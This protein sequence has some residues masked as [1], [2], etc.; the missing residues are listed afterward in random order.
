MVTAPIR[1]EFQNADTGRARPEGLSPRCFARVRS[2]HYTAGTEGAVQDVVFPGRRSLGPQAS[3]Q[4]TLV[5]NRERLGGS[6]VQMTRRR[7]LANCTGRRVACVASDLQPTTAAST[8][9][10]DARHQR[11]SRLTFCA[12]CALRTPSKIYGSFPFSY[13]T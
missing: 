13:V 9:W 3:E 12:A 11:C 1:A 10:Q 7:H 4:P 2:F 5:Q 6:M 8:I